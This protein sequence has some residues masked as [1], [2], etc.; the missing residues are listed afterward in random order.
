MRFNDEVICDGYISADGGIMVNGILIVDE[1]GNFKAA[2]APPSYSAGDFTVPGDQRVTGNLAVETRLR[3]TVIDVQNLEVS[4]AADINRLNITES[5]TLNGQPLPGL[6]TTPTFDSVTLP[7]AT[8][9]FTGEFQQLG[10]VPASILS[11]QNAI[12][13]GTDALLTTVFLPDTPGG[14]RGDYA[15]LANVPAVLSAFTNDQNFASNNHDASFASVLLADL[16]AP[17]TG[18]Y[19]Q[20][21]NLPDLNAPLAQ[22]AAANYVSNGSHPTFT[23]VTLP[24]GR[25]PFTGD[26]AQLGNSPVVLS[27]FANDQNFVSNS[28][29]VSFASVRLPASNGAFVGNYV[30]LTG[31]PTTLSAFRNDLDLTANGSA[32]NFSSIRLPGLPPGGTF[33]G[34]YLGLSG[35]PTL[36]SAFTNDQRFVSNAT[37][38]DFTSITLPASNG[39]FQGAYSQL[40]GVPTDLAAFRN[41]PDFVANGASANLTS[42]RFPAIPGG[43]SGAYGQLTGRPSDLAAFT[44]SPGYVANGSSAV[45]TSLLLPD[46]VGSFTG[47]YS[48]L[49]G[50][51]TRVSTFQNDAAYVSNNKSAAFTS[52]SLPASNGAFTGAYSTLTGVPTSL[53]A[54]SNDATGYVANGSAANFTAVT[55]PQAPEFVGNFFQLS[56]RPTTLSAFLNDAG[57]VSNNKSAAFTSVSLTETP[58]FTGNYAQLSN[59]PNV[60][61]LA[62]IP[63]VISFFVNDSGYVANDGSANFA[64]LSLPNAPTF[65]GNYA[66]LQNRPVSLAAFQNTPGYVA[67]GGDATFNSVSLPDAGG[68]TGQYGQLQGRPTTLSFF[69]NDRAFASNGKSANF[70]SVLLPASNGAFTGA[71]S[72]LSGAPTSLS[73][74][75]ND[76][77][78]VTGGGSVAFSSITLPDAASTFTGRYNQLGGTPSQVSFFTNDAGYLSNGGV[79]AFTSLILPNAPTFTGNYKDLLGRPAVVSAFLNDVGY[80]ANGSDAA[81]SNISLPAAPTFNGFYNQLAGR[82]VALSAFV[83]D[84]EYVAN[85]TSA[86]FTSIILPASNGAFTANYATLTGTPTALSAFQNDPG[87][88]AN[89]S[90]ANFTAVLLP[91]ASPFTG[92]FVQ[93]SGRPVALSAFRN[94]SGFVANGGPVSFTSVTLPNATFTGLYSEISGV[95]TALSAFQNDRAYVSNGAAN[96]VSISL[97]ASNGAFTGNYTT[98]S[99]VPVALSAF[100]N[101]LSFVSNGAANFVSIS[102]PASNGAFTGNYTTL[103]GVPVALSAFRNDLSF[104]S[105]GVANFV[106]ISLPASNGAF[107]GNYTTLTG[108]PVALSAFQNDRAFVSNGASANFT[109]IVLPASNGAFTANYTTLTGVPTALSAFQNDRAYV[110]NGAA[111]FVSI[112]LPASNG[113]FTGNYTTLSGVPVALSAFRNDLSF[114]S[115]ASLAA[116]FTTGV[117]TAN[118]LVVSNASSFTG[119]TAADLTVSNSSALARVTANSLVVLNAASFA[120]VTAAD[121][122]VSNS[123]A[124]ARV[125]ANTLT[126]SNAASFASL[127]A[128]TLVSN[129]FTVR[130][131]ASFAGVTANTI[132]AS[133][134]CSFAALTANTL[135]VANASYFTDLTVSNAASFSGDVTAQGVAVS[136]VLSY[137]G[138]YA[139]FQQAIRGAGNATYLTAGTQSN[140]QQL[141]YITYNYFRGA[142]TPP[143]DTPG[144]FPRYNT[145]FGKSHIAFLNDGSVGL[146]SVP[147]TDGTST[148][149]P[150]RLTVS[151]N[152]VEVAGNIN[153]TGGLYQG[154]VPFTSSQQWTTAG[155]SVYYLGNVA[156]NTQIANSSLTVSGAVNVISGVAG[157]ALGYNGGAGDRL[158][159]FPGTA[160]VYP[161]SIGIEGGTMWRSVPSGNQHKWYVG[162][163]QA[164]TLTATQLTGTGATFSS[165]LSAAGIT[166]NGTETVLSDAGS[167]A[168]SGTT[169]AD[170]SSW[171]TSLNLSTATNLAGANK[172]VLRIGALPF[173]APGTVGFGSGVIQTVNPGVAAGPLYIQPAGGTVVVGRSDILTTINGSLVV[174]NTAT[175]A[176]G[177]FTGYLA[178][179]LHT[180]TNTLQGFPTLGAN[181]GAGDRVILYTGDSANVPYSLGIEPPGA[182][183]YPRMWYSV[184]L[185]AQHKFYVAGSPMASIGNTA[186]SVNVPVT[187]GTGL[188]TFSSLAVNNVSTFSVATANTLNVSNLASFSGVTA[189]TLTVSNTATVSSDA[190]V[191]GLAISGALSYAGGFAGMQQTLSGVGGVTYLTTGHQSGAGLPGYIAYNY[192]RGAPTPAGDTPGTFSRY[193]TAFGK[194]H[195]AFLNDGSINFGSAPST[196][197]SSNIPTNRLTVSSGGTGG[198]SAYVSIPNGDALTSSPLYGLTFPNSSSRFPSAVYIGESTD[199][200][201]GSKRAALTLGSGW[202]LYQDLGANGV[203]DFNIYAAGFGTALQIA[204][205]SGNTTVK[206]NLTTAGAIVSSVASNDARLQLTN[207]TLN[208]LNMFAFQ[209]GKTYMDLGTSLTAG[210]GQLVVRSMNGTSGTYATFSTTGVSTVGV[211]SSGDISTTGTG[212]VVSGANGF[213]AQNATTSALSLFPFSDGKV[214]LLVGTSGSTGAAQF[215]IKAADNS[216]TYATFSS[217]GLSTLAISGT[218]LGLTGTLTQTA[219]I[220]EYRFS[221]TGQGTDGKLW[222]IGGNGPNFYGYTYND[223]GTASTNWL[224]VVRS[225]NTISSVSFPN[226][227]VSTGGA[228]TA[229]GPLSALTGTF[230][231]AVSGTTGTFTGAVSGTTG[232]FTGALNSSSGQSTVTQ[233]QTLYDAGSTHTNGTGW[234]DASTWQDHIVLTGG[235]N[236]TGLGRSRLRISALNISS[237]GGGA[238][239]GLGSATIQHINNFFGA[240]PL[241]LQ[242][243]GGQVVVGPSGFTSNGAAVFQGGLKIG[244]A[245]TSITQQLQGK[246]TTGSVGANSNFTG[247]VAFSNAFTAVPYIQATPYA[248]D[249]TALQGVAVTLYSVTASGF[250]YNITN[251]SINTY[252]TAGIMWLASL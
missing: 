214:Y 243:A 43:F 60:A 195:I 151:S 182:T 88:V 31:A 122:T 112:S 156:I 145:A 107:T 199:A 35:R 167:T 99:G 200:A 18:D 158:I 9:P 111:N 175:F 246:F 197:S 252:T 157:P 125:T 69:T 79:A 74:F 71:Y 127:T 208:T 188:S 21:G 232:S 244:N 98:L 62:N 212:T 57:Y 80:V 11:A 181:G 75:T 4:V 131:A 50:V 117:L 207:G 96:F 73:A 236:Q 239:S 22:I 108:V 140:T 128:D 30:G 40:T 191:A 238:Y 34:N 227:T 148:L 203:K 26:Y 10:N 185:G 32:A 155:N 27:A 248:T 210:A 228:F 143:G 97:P 6:T 8:A 153:F 251:A 70:T 142:A 109:S 224:Q 44:N 104:V 115:N 3:S 49:S 37:N 217:T 211:T 38:T 160:S 134:A 129:A 67:N 178:A 187:S 102:L 242:P 194:S 66:D 45:F 82:P 169:W 65:T 33:V 245:G 92:N 241:Y 233:F 179:N 81:F 126:V 220:P 48:A 206:G 42:V 68:F 213:R 12:A 146:G 180:T 93:L 171:N 123:S 176:S 166:C 119:L 39:A 189:N 229:G 135:T 85:G 58:F 87:F 137:A 133:N 7:D 16:A 47:N 196:D 15:Q 72:T 225:A 105:N 130:N 90:V 247:T 138:G 159:L 76:P 215:V 198:S 36:L 51:P 118:A 234:T 237:P 183:A 186:L 161:Y 23:S 154:G 202:A 114:V 52:V 46:A 63:S 13:N 113:A 41:S 221:V 1:E 84:R 219:T 144:T 174:S 250:G 209:D 77:G 2:L 24:D 64:L 55:L 116:G 59:K 29:P 163:A 162:G 121:L 78:F 139:G 147:N 100:Q 17:F 103:T 25:A 101:D 106:S 164:A 249:G 132:T 216:S 56:S 192:F 235:A 226:G 223:A 168:A 20:L 120:G 150:N 53:A 218:T 170:P 177:S 204:P 165:S 230:T 94:D 201:S 184:P 136:G 240:G 91:E 61:A 86:S 54:F 14:F 110:S 124:L 190:N 89:G 173:Q 83:N 95:P 19:S 5:V 193:N 205:G 141:A 28:Q 231:G 222:A 149:P 152:G 172:S